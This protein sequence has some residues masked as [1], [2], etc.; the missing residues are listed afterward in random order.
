MRLWWCCDGV[1][2]GS[3]SLKRRRVK[4]GIVVLAWIGHCEKWRWGGNVLLVHGEF[5]IIERESSIVRSS[6]LLV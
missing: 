6:R 4:G 2:G 3:G 1:G 5:R